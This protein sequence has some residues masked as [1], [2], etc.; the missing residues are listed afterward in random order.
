MKVKVRVSSTLVSFSRAPQAEGRLQVWVG[1]AYFSK[2][3][4]R[5]SL[6]PSAAQLLAWGDPERAQAVMILGFL[7]HTKAQ[8][9]KLSQGW[10]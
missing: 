5:N 2:T 7:P 1:G 10:A 9:E 3:R 6:L 8:R 4:S